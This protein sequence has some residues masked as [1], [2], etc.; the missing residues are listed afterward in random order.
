M[1]CHERLASISA[2][3]GRKPA[4]NRY[5]AATKS[6]RIG[7]QSEH[8]RRP[9][10]PQRGSKS[11]LSTPLVCTIGY[12]ILATSSTFQGDWKMSFFCAC[13]DLLLGR[14]ARF[15]G[16]RRRVLPLYPPSLFRKEAGIVSTEGRGVGLPTLRSSRNSLTCWSGSKISN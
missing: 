4:R 7:Q 12:R 13:P 3:P 11:S 9:T 6:A 5:Y 14:R 8:L 1:T 16:S 2:F 15:R 10:S